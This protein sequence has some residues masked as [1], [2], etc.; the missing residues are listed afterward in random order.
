[1]FGSVIVGKLTL[2]LDDTL[3][4]F[5]LALVAVAACSLLTLE[6]DDCWRLV[7]VDEVVDKVAVLEDRE[8]L[9]DVVVLTG[10]VVTVL[11]G[12]RGSVRS[13]TTFD[14]S[15]WVLSLPTIAVAVAAWGL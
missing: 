8:V 14:A 2:E 9:D 3:S 11:S 6:L 12:E 10:G 5:V 4:V 15:E 7:S 1:M 13:T